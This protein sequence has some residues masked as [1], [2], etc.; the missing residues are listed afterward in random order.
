MD[1]PGIAAT[2]VI[3]LGGVA[4]TLTVGFLVCYV[5]KLLGDV[6]IGG[7]GGTFYSCRNQKLP[8]RTCD[9][10]DPVFIRTKVKVQILERSKGAVADQRVATQAQL[11]E[12]RLFDIARDGRDLVTAQIYDFEPGRAEEEFGG[13]DARREGVVISSEGLQVGEAHESGGRQIMQGVETEVDELEFCE[14]HEGLGEEDL[15]L[16]MG[17]TQMGQFGVV[18][19]HVAIHI[20]EPVVG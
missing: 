8:R 19:E 3:L 6:H 12:M 5:S 17:E 7:T 9:L 2:I 10:L 4:A 15:Q 11:G 20:A 13:D 14:V 16:V 1:D 18:S